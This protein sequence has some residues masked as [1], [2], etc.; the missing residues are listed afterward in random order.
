M[1]CWTTKT[2]ASK[3]ENQRGPQFCC[4]CVK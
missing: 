4:G 2:T 1:P 3:F